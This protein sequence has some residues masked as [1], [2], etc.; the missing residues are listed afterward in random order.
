M[1]SYYKFCDRIINFITIHNKNGEIN[2]LDYKIVRIFEMNKLM[3]I[4][5]IQLKKSDL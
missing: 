3:I 2:V 1:F 5:N 4:K